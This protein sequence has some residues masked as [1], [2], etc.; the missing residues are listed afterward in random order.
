MELLDRYVRQ[1]RILESVERR[2]LQSNSPTE[3]RVVMA[4][5]FSYFKD[6]DKMSESELDS[7]IFNE[8]VALCDAEIK[9]SL[10]AYTFYQKEYNLE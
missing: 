8:I 6:I 3:V 2:H 7:F 1:A 10:D 5:F 4:D 9:T